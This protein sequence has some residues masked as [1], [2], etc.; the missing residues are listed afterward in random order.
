MRP[1]VYVEVVVYSLRLV[2]SGLRYRRHVNVVERGESEG[3]LG[4]ED[5]SLSCI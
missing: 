2:F 3:W 1:G 4:N 5:V